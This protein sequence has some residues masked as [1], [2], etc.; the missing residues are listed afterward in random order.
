M[1]K[2]DL[3][4]CP[5]CGGTDLHLEL[6]S[7]WGADVV[8]C[9]DCLAIFSQQEITCK[10]DLINAWNTRASGWIPCRERMPDMMADRRPKSGWSDDLKPSDDVLCYTN[11]KRQIV[12][13]YSHAYD[14][15]TD[16]EEDHTY[17]R[18]EITHWRPLPDNPETEDKA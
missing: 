7:G 10:E 9:R 6:F 15:W 18:D 3:L 12:A 2:I 16:V 1:T 11:F 4:N 5:F 13:W 14:E 8:I 17:S